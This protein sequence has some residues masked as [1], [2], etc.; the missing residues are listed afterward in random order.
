MNCR[1]LIDTLQVQ[2][3]DPHGDL[4]SSPR[5]LRQIN[6]ALRDISS[7]SRSIDIKGFLI[8]VDSQYQY[9]LPNNFLTMHRVAFNDGDWYPLIPATLSDLVTGGNLK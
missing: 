5:L 4:H 7:R 3:G 6:Q 8:A 2:L 1:E 9:G